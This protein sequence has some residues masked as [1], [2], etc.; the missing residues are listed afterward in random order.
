MFNLVLKLLRIA[1]YEVKKSTSKKIQVENV[2]EVYVCMCMK[3]YN[4][5]CAY[6]HN[7]ELVN[8]K[9]TIFVN[10]SKL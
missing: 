6:I 9:V 2:I 10:F 3:A 4:K 1:Q 5:I 7:N 8:Y